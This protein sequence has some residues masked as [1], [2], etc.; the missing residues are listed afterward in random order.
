MLYEVITCTQTNHLPAVSPTPLAEILPTQTDTIIPQP[1]LTPSLEATVVDYP[2][3]PSEIWITF[4]SEINDL[5]FEF[6]QNW[7]CTHKDTG[8]GR[9][10]AVIINAPPGEIIAIKGTAPGFTRIQVDKEATA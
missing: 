2:A 8:N 1:T 9:S 4:Y 5:Y 10:A 3:A 7:F 6:P